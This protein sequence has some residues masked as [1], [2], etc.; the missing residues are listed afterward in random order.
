[1]TFDSP[2][3]AKPDAFAGFDSA[4]RDRFGRFFG[5][6]FSFVKKVDCRLRLAICFIVVN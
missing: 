3:P 5:G 1:M 4:A 2:M 6:F